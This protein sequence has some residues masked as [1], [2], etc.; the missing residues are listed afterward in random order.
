MRLAPTQRLLAA[1]LVLTILLAPAGAFAD[2]TIL[3]PGSNRFTPQ[4][5]IELG[6]KAA[7]DAEKKLPMCNAPEV[8]AYL[9]KLG[10]KLIDHLNTGGVDYPWEFHCV[11]DKAVNAFA[12]PG[13]FV[14]VNR[15]A[16]EVA[17]YEAEL[18]GVMAHELSHVA[19]RHGTNQVTK[20]Q[21]AQ[22][23]TGILSAAA[24]V[25][26]GAAGTAIGGL[27][28][29]AAGGMLL[30]Y[31]RGAETQ[32]DVMGTQ[33]L[34]D[35]GYD[36]RA[37]AAFFEK[38]STDNSGKNPPTFFSDHPSPDNRVERVQEEI[39]KLGGVPEGAKRDSA[40]FE[41]IK[42][43]VMA[44]PVVKKSQAPAAQGSGA[45]P[46]GTVKVGPPSENYVPLQAG[47]YA[48]EYPDNW[49]K[50]GKGND[51]TL[52]PD[53]GVV[54]SGNGQAALAYGVIASVV[55]IQGK[56]PANAD[57]LNAATHKL[58]ET[59]QQEN[60]NMKVTRESKPVTLNGEQ[61]LSTYLE[62][63]S[64]A[65]GVETDWLIT[66]LRPEGLVYFV[67]AAPRDEYRNFDKAFGA[68]LDSVRF[69]M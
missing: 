27:G 53:G 21:N 10:R 25:F 65:G 43:Q 38:I 64:P 13:G 50:Y 18:A 56:P 8:D 42:R 2:R 23:L 59:L 40:E 57:V 11:N 5:D 69:G 37:L 15:G 14:F 3:K 4:Q 68:I 28:Q 35:A 16:I 29:F 24:G 55:Q 22:F 30:K 17:D 54:D 39:N 36:P 46:P 33:V 49:K 58:I 52:A 67:C 19:L 41:S 51:V 45:P 6:Q 34:Y 1:G 7:Q 9:T 48:L 32:A 62:N 44:L 31:S 61:G 66:V 63:D 60:A 12:L 26:G 47:A 20:A